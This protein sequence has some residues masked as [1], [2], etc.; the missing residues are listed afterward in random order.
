MPRF[1]DILFF[2]Y[3]WRFF[4]EKIVIDIDDSADDFY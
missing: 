1:S 2:V 4:D 3:N